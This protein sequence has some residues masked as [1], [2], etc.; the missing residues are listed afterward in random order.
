MVHSSLGAEESIVLWYRVQIWS[1]ALKDT[2]RTTT[3]GMYYPSKAISRNNV[4]LKT[5]KQ[6]HRFWHSAV[7]V[8]SGGI[9]LG[10]L[11]Y[12]CFQ[13]HVNPTTVGL[14][15]LI[16]IVLVS[17][18][19]SLLPAA[20]V[21]IIAYF[22]LDYFF[23]APLF[24]LGMNQTLDYV[25]PIAYL[26]IAVV[27]TRLMA[28]VRKSQEDQKRAE[29]TLRRSQAELAH[30]RRVMTMGELAASIAHEINQPLSAIVN[31][32]SACLRWLDG[33]SP[34]LVEA[35]EA[36]RRIVRDGNRAAEV[37]TRIRG[38]LRKTE[39]AKS[40]LDINQTIREI[41]TVIKQE[42][43]ENRVDLRMDLASDILP[44]WGDRV[45][46]QQVILNLLMNGVEAMAAITERPRRLSISTRK[47]DPDKVLVIVRDSGM[48][49]DQESLE[50]IFDAFYTTKAQGMGMGLAIS[51]SIVE[52]HG[53][54]LWAVTN[55]GS[56]ATFQFT[57]LQQK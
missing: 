40:R 30:V 47:H 3:H 49:I 18:R 17:L 53:G 31:N 28:R 22:C 48:G 45:Q 36:A 20:L 43:V 24:A 14:L 19:A 57:L 2:W 4:M 13:F 1:A 26:I 11:S 56:G 10:L 37:I 38:F 46:L 25:A 15:F 8:L 41:V 44:V 7:L 50:K 54:E 27:I 5:F 55:N 39:S 34:D 6:P 35:R 21:S 51:R 16:V 33:D 29:E 9:A 12:V 32:G 42:A 52:D 23:T